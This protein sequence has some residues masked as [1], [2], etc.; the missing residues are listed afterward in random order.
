MLVLLLAD[1]GSTN[2]LGP[3]SAIGVAAVLLAALTLL[4]AMLTWFG[5][6]GFWPGRYAAVQYQ[7][8]A[9]SEE[10]PGLWRRFGDRVLQRPGL[11]LGATVALFGVFALGLLSYK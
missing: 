3:V 10:R 6:I 7:P 4:P 5:R 1:A 2:G 11:A 8:D 9:Q